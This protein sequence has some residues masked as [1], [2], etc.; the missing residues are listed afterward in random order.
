MK[1]FLLFISAIEMQSRFLQ[2][3]IIHSCVSLCIQCTYVSYCDRWSMDLLPFDQMSGIDNRQSTIVRFFITNRKIPDRM[4]LASKRLVANCHFPRVSG[5]SCSLIAVF[6][7]HRQ[8][9]LGRG[10]ALAYIR[11]GHSFRFLV[12]ST[13]LQHLNLLKTGIRERPK[14]RA[15]KTP[16]SIRLVKSFRRLRVLQ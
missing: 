16:C 13:C 8:T 5:C 15:N 14:T 4:V 11:A 12:Y 7:V 3:L 10:A 6:R 2:Y 1:T 9:T